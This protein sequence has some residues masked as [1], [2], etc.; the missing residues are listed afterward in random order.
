MPVVVV[1]LLTWPD[2]T[3]AST[4]GVVLAVVSGA[5]TSA[6]G[7]SLWS[8]L[9]PSLGATRAALSQ[10]SAPAIALVLGAALLGETITAS[11]VAASVLIL[12][13]IAGTII[14]SVISR[15][16]AAQKGRLNTIFAALILGV[17]LY[18]AARSIAA[19]AA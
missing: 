1:T 18:M 12:G 17:A 6:L 7:Y 14:G 4:R 3:G 19:L 13:G 5:V 11:A 9:L 10:L 8:S 16:L 2:S 15:R